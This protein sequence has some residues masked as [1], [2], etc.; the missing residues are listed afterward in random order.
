MSE[1]NTGN[2]IEVAMVE[3]YVTYENHGTLKLN[4]D[5]W[6]DLKGKDRAAISAWLNE[7]QDNLFVDAA[8]GTLRPDRYYR[9]T[10]ED[11]A[12]METNGDEKE[13][14]EDVCT[15]GDYWSESECVSSNV[16]DEHR[17]LNVS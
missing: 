5:D 9:Y 1:Q 4:L 7:N 16:K 2:T 17:Y 6:P 13:I 14:N 12:E 3:S 15:L 8:D 11:L 10:A